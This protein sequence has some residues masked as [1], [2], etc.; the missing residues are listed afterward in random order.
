M[1]DNGDHADHERDV[2]D[3]ARRLFRIDSA[4]GAG[5]FL[6]LSSASRSDFLKTWDEADESTRRIYRQQARPMVAAKHK[7]ER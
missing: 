5:A 4:A 7:G 6:F 2:E 3:L 1:G